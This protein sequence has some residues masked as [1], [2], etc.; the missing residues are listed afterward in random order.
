MACLLGRG[1]TSL[2][3]LSLRCAIATPNMNF[4][5]SHDFSRGYFRS[6]FRNFTII[7]KILP[8]AEK[9]TSKLA[10]SLTYSYLYDFVK[11]LLGLQ[12]ALLC[13]DKPTVVATDANTP[14][15]R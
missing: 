14:R 1:Q 4:F 8:F 7:V 3:L 6:L 13:V 11:K 12:A 9:H 5:H 2:S 10:V 15:R